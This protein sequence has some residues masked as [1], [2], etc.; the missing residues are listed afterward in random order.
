LYIG[1]KPFN[2]SFLSKTA[3]LELTTKKAPFD[4]FG[5]QE[6]TQFAMAFCQ[7]SNVLVVRMKRFNPSITITF[8]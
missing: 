5:I 3:L 1:S 8:F 2:I 4:A 6:N 7:A